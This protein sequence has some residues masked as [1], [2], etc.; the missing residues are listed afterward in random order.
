[1]ELGKRLSKKVSKVLSDP[2]CK[3]KPCHDKTFLGGYSLAVFCV[4]PHHEC[5]I[6]NKTINNIEGCFVKSNQR[7]NI[8]SSC[9]LHGGMGTDGEGDFF[10]T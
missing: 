9:S 3:P 1:V 8:F 2:M 4:H 5:I 10:L 7:L 6:F